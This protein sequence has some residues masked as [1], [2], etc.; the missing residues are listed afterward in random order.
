MTNL[1]C[2][3]L[4]LFSFS[5]SDS[6]EAI[7]NAFKFSISKDRLVYHAGENL[8][9]DF[10]VNIDKGYHVYSSHPDDSS[11]IKLP[12]ESTPVTCDEF[13][14]TGPNPIILFNLTAVSPRLFFPH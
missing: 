1:F 12:L 3:I 10:N 9:L 5:F 2:I 13:N 8:Y 14:K 11:F 6:M 4:F 7:K